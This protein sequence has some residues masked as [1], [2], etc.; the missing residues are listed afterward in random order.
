MLRSLA[1]TGQC[2]AGALQHA[3]SAL[4][5]SEYERDAGF[6]D[7]AAC[8]APGVDRYNLNVQLAEARAVGEFLEIIE[9]NAVSTL[10]EP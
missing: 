4:V 3:Y 7:L 2:A 9:A 1:R 8:A 10:R 5:R 6:A